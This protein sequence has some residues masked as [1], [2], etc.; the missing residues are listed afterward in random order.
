MSAAR[1][2]GIGAGAGDGYANGYGG[3]T[4]PLEW[5][6]YCCGAAALTDDMNTDETYTLCG[7][8]EYLAPEVIQS[9]GHTAAVD[10]WALGILMYE[11]ITGYPPFWHQSPMEIYKQCAPPSPPP[12]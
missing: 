12:P 6:K 9:Q 5:L 3:K 8:P 10:W 2:P 7:T 11:F 4:S 1:L